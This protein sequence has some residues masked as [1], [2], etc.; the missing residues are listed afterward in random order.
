MH[1]VCFAS[2]PV[3]R[4][5]GYISLSLQE[6]NL[7]SRPPGYG[8][9]TAPDMFNHEL[10]TCINYLDCYSTTGIGDDPEKNMAVGAGAGAGAGRTMIKTV[11][12][13]DET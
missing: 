1:L 8:N 13:G 9:Y 2:E 6:T 3:C 12:P 11:K 10:N 4:S 5:S 7:G